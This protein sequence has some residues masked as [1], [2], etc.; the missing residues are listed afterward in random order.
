[1]CN[2]YEND[3]KY[4]DKLIRKKHIKIES[5]TEN[6]MQKKLFTLIAKSFF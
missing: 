6:T 3:C 1:M 2:I 5:I 4:N